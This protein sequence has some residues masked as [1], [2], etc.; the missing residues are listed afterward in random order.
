MAADYTPYISDYR[1]ATVLEVAGEK[2]GATR[3]TLQLLGKI[4]RK[5]WDLDVLARRNF[6]VV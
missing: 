5:T 6:T 2:Q 3:L 1:E 4:T